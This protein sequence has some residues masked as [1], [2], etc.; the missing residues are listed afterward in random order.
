MAQGSQMHRTTLGLLSVCLCLVLAG[1][2]GV[3]TTLENFKSRRS[4]YDDACPKW[5]MTLGCPLV[6][7]NGVALSREPDLPWFDK[8]HADGVFEVE[9][10]ANSGEQIVTLEGDSAILNKVRTS[11]DENTHALHLTMAKGYLYNNADKVKVHI[12]MGKLSGLHYAGP[13]RLTA[14]N[15]NANRLVLSGGNKGDMFLTGT[16][17]IL[18]VAARNQLHVHTEGLIITHAM[19]ASAS[20]ASVIT[21]EPDPD[22]VD[23][24]PQDSGAVLR[25][26]GLL[27]QPNACD[28]T[29][30][31]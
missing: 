23:I 4:T 20:G 25:M 3:Q 30:T 14:E 10:T 2:A 9:I 31:C 5:R 24:Y 29:K 19:G 28:K 8:V 6:A 22:L 7:H 11:V 12:R 26:E 13:G 27:D 1:C 17:R 16:V 18:D 15:I 21:Y